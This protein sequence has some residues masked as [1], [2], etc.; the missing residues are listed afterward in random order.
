MC[1][2]STTPRKCASAPM[3]I[4]RGTTRVP[5]F[6]V[7]PATVRAKTAFSRSSR[8]TTTRRLVRLS[9][10]VL[11]AFSVCTSPPPTPRRGG[12]LRGEEGGRAGCVYRFALPPPPLQRRQ[13]GVDRVLA[14]HLFGVEVGGRRALVYAPQA[15]DRLGH[16]EHRFYKRGLACA[17]VS[18][19]GDVVDLVRWI[20][21]HTRT[22]IALAFVHH[23]EQRRPG[24]EAAQVLAEQGQRPVVVVGHGPGD[25]RGEDDLFHLPQGAVLRQGLPLEDVQ[26]RPPQPA[27]AA[28]RGQG[29][30]PPAPPPRPPHSGG[31][32]P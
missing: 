4:C 25:V 18:H 13:R 21:L 17:A 28:R 3:G 26:P 19:H 30:P 10:A 7:S 5:N 12:A 1:S 22:S 31:G 20:R 6:A 24:E 23:V 15:V 11:P 29:R 16:E 32:R 8:L 9:S 2:R 14:P 27:G